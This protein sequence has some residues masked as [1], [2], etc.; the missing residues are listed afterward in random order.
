MAEQPT[1]SPIQKVVND[2]LR[3]LKSNWVWFL[4]LGIVLAVIGVFAISTS[5]ITT[6][7]TIT[8]FGM[9][10]LAAGIAQVI[11]AF[12]SP[13]WSGLFLSPGSGPAL[14]RRGLHVDRQPRSCCR[15]IDVAD[16]RFLNGGRCFFALRQR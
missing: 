6:L 5:F 4:V 14:Y 15:W 8:I 13:K 10:I 1:L 12:S 9:L 3:G 16:R 2:D 7:I 11:S